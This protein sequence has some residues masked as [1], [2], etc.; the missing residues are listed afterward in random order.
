M[1]TAERQRSDFPTTQ[2]SLV[3]ALREQDSEEAREALVGFCHRYWF[4]L[5]AFVRGSGYS[6]G[7]F[8]D[9]QKIA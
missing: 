5:Y 9:R 4:P 7:I 1:S 8:Y 2:W 3:L 6:L